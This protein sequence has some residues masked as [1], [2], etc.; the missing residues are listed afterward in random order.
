MN[1]CLEASDIQEVGDSFLQEF[2]RRYETLDK[3]LCFPFNEE[4][5][6]LE[7][8]L[9]TMYRMVVKIARTIEDIDH[10]GRL[11][12]TMVNLCEQAIKRLDLLTAEHPYCDAEPYRD[13]LS[14]LRN[15]CQ[16]LQTT[17]LYPFDRESDEA[18]KSFNAEL[19][20]WYD[21]CD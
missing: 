18:E 11:W 4:A 13:R 3:G 16:R 7:A 5:R 14:D 12:R 10:V 2:D 1:T 21:G 15:K 19:L 17:H 20:A 6:Q 9:V 8:E